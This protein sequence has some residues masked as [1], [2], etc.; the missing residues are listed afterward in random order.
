M[1]SII[2]INLNVIL[3]MH[4][5]QPICN[6]CWLNEILHRRRK[7][8]YIIFLDVFEGN[9]NSNPR[10]EGIH[11]PTKSAVNSLA[12]KNRLTTEYITD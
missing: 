2:R 11:N 4:A 6:Y 5:F 1:K 12:L 7:K 9:E 3:S 10:I 8:I